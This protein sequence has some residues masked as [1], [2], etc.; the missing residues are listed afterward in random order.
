MDIYMQAAVRGLRGQ[1]VQLRQQAPA[2]DDLARLDETPATR[3]MPERDDCQARSRA[4]GRGSTVT[5]L[6]R[7]GSNPGEPK[8]HGTYH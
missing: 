8:T 2:V 3:A 4:S 1:R 5:F 6:S 7:H